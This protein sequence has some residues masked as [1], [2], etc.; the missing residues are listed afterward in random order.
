M[1]NSSVIEYGEASAVTVV[2]SVEDVAPTLVIAGVSAAVLLVPGQTFCP[3]A[4]S[5]QVIKDRRFAGSDSTTVS[6]IEL[7]KVRFGGVVGAVKPVSPTSIS[8]LALTAPESA[9][10]TEAETVSATMGVP[11]ELDPALR[12]V[13]TRPLAVVVVP[14]QVLP[15]A[16]LHIVVKVTPP[17]IE[18]SASR[19]A[20]APDAQRSG[21]APA[22]AMEAASRAVPRG[23]LLCIDVPIRLNVLGQDRGLILL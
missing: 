4:W 14:T 8:M 6:A 5:M 22:K 10:V 3:S 9:M 17:S 13:S 12:S 2:E 7:I 11:G 15:D 23:I 1:V 19:P 18:Y 16:P 20:C 21:A